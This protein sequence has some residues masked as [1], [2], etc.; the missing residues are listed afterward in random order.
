[1]AGEE[2]DIQ[3]IL[4]EDYEAFMEF[5]AQKDKRAK[6]QSAKEI[7]RAMVSEGGKYYDAYSRLDEQL[8]A[9]WEKANAEARKQVGLVEEEE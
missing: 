2:K 5:K 4:G 6:I 9:I 1:M 7:A 8:S 3:E